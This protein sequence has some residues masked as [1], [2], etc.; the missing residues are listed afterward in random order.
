MRCGWL[1]L[2]VAVATGCRSASRQ[3]VGHLVSPGW[4]VVPPAAYAFVPRYSP[5]PLAS[6]MAS[7]VRTVDQSD[8]SRVSELEKV[9]ERHTGQIEALSDAVLEL[10]ERL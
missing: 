6:G 10:Q 3:P 1:L 5:P 8:A 4:M 9:T 7:S 2:A